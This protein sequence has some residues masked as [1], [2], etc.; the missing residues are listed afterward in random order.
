MISFI[1]GFLAR[2]ISSILAQIQKALTEPKYHM[3]FLPYTFKSKI[4]IQSFS[5]YASTP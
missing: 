2:I 4:F 5:F 3:F 1:N